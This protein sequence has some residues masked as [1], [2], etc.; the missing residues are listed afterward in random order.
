MP[1]PAVTEIDPLA[2]RRTLKYRSIFGVSSRSDRRISPLNASFGACPATGAVG[3]AV[4]LSRAV[5]ASRLS[6]PAAKSQPGRGR[7]AKSFK[8]V[9]KDS[10]LCPSR[11]A[12]AVPKQPRPLLHGAPGS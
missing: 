7:G 3:L 4:A 8:N 11:V 9:S 6:G 5:L 12:S 1:S 10:S 2:R